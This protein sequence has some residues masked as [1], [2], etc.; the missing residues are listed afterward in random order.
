MPHRTGL[1]AAQCL[2]CR[3]GDLPANDP[4]VPDLPLPEKRDVRCRGGDRVWQSQ[5]GSG[6]WPNDNRRRA[7]NSP[8]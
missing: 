4:L 6:A 7:T 5:R 1:A 3:A 8:P 2:A